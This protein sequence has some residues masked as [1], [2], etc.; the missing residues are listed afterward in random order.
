MTQEK[1]TQRYG[2]RKESENSMVALKNV[3]QNKFEDIQEFVD[4]LIDLADSAFRKESTDHSPVNEQL[5]S[6]FIDRIS[7][8]LSS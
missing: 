4:R 7:S 6:H 5:I 3:R 8:D 1:L 2:E